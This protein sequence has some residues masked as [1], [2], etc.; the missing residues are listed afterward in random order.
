MMDCSATCWQETLFYYCFVSLLPPPG[1]FLCILSVYAGFIHIEFF[2]MN[3]LA[4]EW[5]DLSF[6]AVKYTT[7]GL[8]GKP[9]R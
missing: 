7:I 8:S 2:Q 9:F 5:F 1:L 4:I 3:K 6:F